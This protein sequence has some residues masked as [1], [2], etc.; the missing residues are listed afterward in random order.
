MINLIYVGERYYKLSST[1]LSSIYLEENGT[2]GS[3][4]DWGFLQT[5]L[6]KGSEVSIRQAIP[7]EIEIMD[8]ALRRYT[9]KE[10]K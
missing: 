8:D 5:A 7:D 10:N 4:Y 2:L 3:R 1:R 6:E 9:R